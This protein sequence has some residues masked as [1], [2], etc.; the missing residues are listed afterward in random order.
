[1]Y[2]YDI[3]RKGARHNGTLDNKKPCRGTVWS[4]IFKNNPE[5]Q[6]LMLLFRFWPEIP[7]HKTYCLR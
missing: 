4:T 2:N 1:M 5:I 3:G 6:L 7:D